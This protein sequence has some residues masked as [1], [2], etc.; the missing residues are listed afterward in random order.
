[1]LFTPDTFDLAHPAEPTLSHAPFDPDLL[2]F[3]RNRNVKPFRSVTH[4]AL[5]FQAE[6]HGRASRPS[7]TSKSPVCQR[8]VKTS[9][10]S[11]LQNQ[12]PTQGV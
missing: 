6:R 2:T 5:T 4:L 12:Q 3:N 9:S 7:G 11:A 1:M 10:E 8:A